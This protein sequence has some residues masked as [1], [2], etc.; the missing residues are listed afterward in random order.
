MDPNH[1]DF[2]V[3]LMLAHKRHKLE[4]AALMLSTCG[5]QHFVTVISVTAAFEAVCTT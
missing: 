2:D 3:I 4:L 1:S 5:P